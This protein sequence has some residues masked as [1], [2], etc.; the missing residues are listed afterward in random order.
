LNRQLLRGLAE[1]AERATNATEGA[2]GTAA[3][4]SGAGEGCIN[5]EL[6]DPDLPVLG[7][8]RNISLFASGVSAAPT[9]P[10]SGLAVAQ[11]EYVMPSS[12]GE[13]GGDGG[14]GVASD[15]AAKPLCVLLPGATPPPPLL[16]SSPTWVGGR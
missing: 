4:S 12:V 15:V 13:G 16:R 8:A 2:A 9:P 3:G 14:G 11:A 5:I 1:A 10:Q 6:G 7:Q